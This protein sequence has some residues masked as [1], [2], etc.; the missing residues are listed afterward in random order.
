MWSKV[1]LSGVSSGAN[2]KS[3]L[4]CIRAGEKTYKIK[5]YQYIIDDVKK[6]VVFEKISE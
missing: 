5:G 2:R 6:R 4:N 3:L 1:C